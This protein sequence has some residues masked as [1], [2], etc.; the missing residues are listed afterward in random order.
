MLAE[1]QD[2]LRELEVE[3]LRRIA[4]ALEELLGYFRE[5]A[6]DKDYVR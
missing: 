6:K 5:W 3:S 4:R 1:R 2:E